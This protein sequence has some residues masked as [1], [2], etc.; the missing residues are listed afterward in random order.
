MCERGI[1]QGEGREHIA[2]ASARDWDGGAQHH[3]PGT[4][5]KNKKR[6]GGQTGESVRKN[7]R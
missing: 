3:W 4:G 7:K 6:R 5:R 1:D 2:S